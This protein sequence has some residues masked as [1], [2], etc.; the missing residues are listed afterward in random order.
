MLP[1][2]NRTI[3]RRAPVIEGESPPPMAVAAIGDVYQVH[4][5][6]MRR[7]CVLLC[8]FSTLVD[9]VLTVTL[10][11]HHRDPTPILP[12]TQHPCMQP[13]STTHTHPFLGAVVCLLPS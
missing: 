13:P 9:F 2:A 7:L 6:Y 8:S 3:G 12:P 11:M 5:K 4:S 10:S 1:R